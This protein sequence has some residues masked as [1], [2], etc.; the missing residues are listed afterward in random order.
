MTRAVVA[1]P[2]KPAAPGAAPVPAAPALR[3]PAL[4]AGMPAPS[5]A[6][7]AEAEGLIDELLEG[8][9]PTGAV[10]LE[11]VR[12]AESDAARFVIL[13]RAEAAFLKAHAFAEALRV[14]DCR[15][16]AFKGAVTDAEAVTLAKEALRAHAVRSPDTAISHATA[17]LAFAEAHRRPKVAAEVIRL[18]NLLTR[19][20][21]K[22]FRR[23]AATHYAKGKSA[24]VGLRIHLIEKRIEEGSAQ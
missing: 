22:A 19:H 23:H 16:R 12:D 10:L 8:E 9:T 3:I 13:R 5:E 4:P 17:T 21:V 7:T 14:M 20:L 15:A 24:A 11:Y 2:A 1:P 18:A 6:E